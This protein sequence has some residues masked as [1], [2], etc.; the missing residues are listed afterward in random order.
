[1]LFMKVRKLI[2]FFVYLFFALLVILIG[3]SVFVYVTNKPPV[4]EISLARE[5]LASAK[6]K[7]AGRYA[8]ETL[9]EAERLYKWSM[10][11]W[12]TQ[13]GK[14]FVFRDYSL[15]RDLA[16]K[17]INKSTNAGSEAKNVKSKLKNKVESELATLRKQIAKFEKYYK[18]LALG[19]STFNAFNKGKTRFLEAQIEYKKNDYQQAANLAK[20]ATESISQAEK[21]AH[22]KLTEFYKNYPE[23]EKNTKLAYNLSKKGQTVILVDKIQSTFL[24]LK[25]GK[26]FKTFPAE[27]G[28][29][30]MGDKMYAGDKAT[31]EGVYK[32]LEKKSRAKTK[33]YKALLI[34]YPNSEDQKR[35]DKMVRSGEISRRTGIGGLIEIHGDGGKGVNWTDGCIALENKQM[36]VVFSQCSVNTPVI[37]VGSRLPLEDY[38]N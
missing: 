19:R 20:K 37:I 30:W 15:T 2:S 29:S 34:N 36:D 1:M 6:N 11:E 7:K 9:R 22:F 33:Y 10:K 5:S 12:E 31:P 13:N 35:Y 28:K 3:Y 17:S 21:S 14:F 38:L 32:V 24:I 8:S 26:E 4:E 27:F 18:H 25:E 16:L 23:W